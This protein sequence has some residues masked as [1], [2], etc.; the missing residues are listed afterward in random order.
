[1]GLLSDMFGY[2]FA[3]LDGDPLP[4]EE[5]SSGLP[6]LCFRNVHTKGEQRRVDKSP[7]QALIPACCQ[8]TLPNT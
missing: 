6:A 2:G 3:D 8:G 1:M 5:I 7:R 4:K